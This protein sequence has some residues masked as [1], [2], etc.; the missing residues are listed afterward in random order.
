MPN[1][2]ASHHERGSPTLNSVIKSHKYKLQK[3][4]VV[5]LR[6]KNTTSYFKNQ[7]FGKTIFFIY[8]IIIIT[9]SFSLILLPG[10][11]GHSDKHHKMPDKY[12]L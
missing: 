8:K 7:E 2:T 12:S 1:L 5:I 3:D 9:I 11:D 4:I 10:K 6:R